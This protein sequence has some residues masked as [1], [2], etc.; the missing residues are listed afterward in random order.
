MVLKL[1]FFRKF[2]QKR[3]GACISVDGNDSLA[4][5]FVFCPSTTLQV[6]VRLL[7]LGLQHW[8][9]ASLSKCLRRPFAPAL[10]P[11]TGGLF[12]EMKNPRIDGSTHVNTETLGEKS[13]R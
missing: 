2:L 5:L 6:N 7:E 3:C 9:A 8:V 4:S 12:Y 10:L 11:S 1:N 13:R